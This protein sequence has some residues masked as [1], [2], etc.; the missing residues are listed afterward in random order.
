MGDL[1][2]KYSPILL[3]ARVCDNWNCWRRDTDSLVSSL[4]NFEL[5]SIFQYQ[6]FKI[7]DKQLGR[8]H[9]RQLNS[10]ASYLYLFKA[11]IFVSKT[12]D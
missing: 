10:F 9:S 2:S 4:D 5:K 11:A 7:C 3:S 1:G 12:I 8:T 6:S